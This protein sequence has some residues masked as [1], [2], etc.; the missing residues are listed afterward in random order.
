MA[1]IVEPYVD[2]ENCPLTD[3][4][5]PENRRAMEAS[6]EKVRKELGKTYPLIIGEER[7]SE[8]KTVASVNPADPRQE[9]G[10]FVEATTD[11]ADRALDVATE[12]FESWKRT[13]ADE[14]AVY[15]DRAADVMERR[16]FELAAWMVYEVSKSWVEADADV[17]ELIDFTRYYAIQARH[18]GGSQPVVE[19]PGE[20]NEMRY[21]PLGVCAIIPPWNFPSAIMGGMTLAAVV[22]GNT[23]VLKPA[24]TSTIIAAKFVEI[25]LGDEVGLPPGVINFVP[26]PGAVVGEYLVDDP[27]TRLIAFTGS[28]AVGVRIYERAARVHPGQKWLKRSV[29]EMGGKDA[30]VVDETADLDAAAEGITMAAF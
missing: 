9:V 6:L 14:R 25:M 13:T 20:H 16:R 11:H 8:G 24:E 19:F 29:L 15:L 21:L 5:D 4:S 12:A 3:F 30:I 7:V 17:A 10:R 22:S 26:G 27:R 18:M 1:T 2:F 28:R 23:A